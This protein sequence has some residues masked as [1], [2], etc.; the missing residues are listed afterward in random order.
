MK[1]VKAYMSVV[2]MDL[3]NI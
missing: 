3:R 2:W 1:A